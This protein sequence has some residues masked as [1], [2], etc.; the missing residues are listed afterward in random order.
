MEQRALFPTAGNELSSLP[1]LGSLHFSDTAFT[2]LREFVALPI[3]AYARARPRMAP[4]KHRESLWAPRGKKICVCARVYGC[5]SGKARVA[6][7]VFYAA[8]S[9]CTRGVGDN[10]GARRLGENKFK[11]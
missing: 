3:Y 10:N 9:V 2:A 7:R 6:G 4:S 1:P 5:G 8:S 11:S